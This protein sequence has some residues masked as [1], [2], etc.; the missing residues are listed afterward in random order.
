MPE[1]SLIA[2]TT[3]LAPGGYHD[4][5]HVTLSA[6]YVAAVEAQGGTSVLLTPAHARASVER[7]LDLADGLLLTG[8]EDVEPSRYGQ[9]PHPKLG[10]VTP[11]RDEL[12]LFVLERALERNLPVLA[13][14]RGMQVLN[15][16]LGGTL[17]QDLIAQ[18]AGGVIHEQAAPA[19]QRWHGARVDP[20]SR[21][22]EIFGADALTINSFHHQGIDRLAPGLRASVWADDG[23]IEAV[24]AEG[25]PWVFGVQWHPERGEAEILRDRRDP[26]RR[27]FYAFL[28][29]T[30]G[31]VTEGRSA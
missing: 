26:D 20:G 15:V 1:T 12:E 4:L 17:Y 8:G 28:A 31:T 11:E 22:H 14:C 18:R 7:V 19:S 9:E 24:E 13:I 25:Y 2:V 21:L 10:R 30:R 16:G 23:L 5:P 6:Q 29:A 3:S 27:L